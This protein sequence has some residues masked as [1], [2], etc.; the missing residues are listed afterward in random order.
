[1]NYCVCSAG[2]HASVLF[3]WIKIS[4]SFFKVKKIICSR[5]LHIFLI[6]LTVLIETCVVVY[7]VYLHYLQFLV[8]RTTARKKV[9]NPIDEQ[10]TLH[11]TRIVCL[12]MMRKLLIS[13]QKSWKLTN[14]SKQKF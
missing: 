8:I 1:M 10:I 5:P 2:L 13:F 3:Q 14:I 6:L 4:Y 11:N 9:S 12:V 7:C